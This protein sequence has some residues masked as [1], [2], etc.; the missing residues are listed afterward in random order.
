[1]RLFDYD[2]QIDNTPIL[3]PD[4]GV[5]ISKSDLDSEDS[6]RDESGVMHRQ[7]VREKVV[8]LN[9]VYA[10][11]T[12]EEYQYMESLFQGKPTFTVTYLDLNGRVAEMTAYC[13]KLSISLH[14]ART[15]VYRNL[16]FSIVEC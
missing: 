6:G 8:T 2:F 1:M 4:E 15:G 10:V 14:N 11:L 3:M 7:V 13:S 12:R 16:K 5:E 9:L